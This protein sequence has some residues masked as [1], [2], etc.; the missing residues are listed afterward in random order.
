[1]SVWRK[2]ENIP[3]TKMQFRILRLLVEKRT[4]CRAS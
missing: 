3:L 1:M 4:D 2:G